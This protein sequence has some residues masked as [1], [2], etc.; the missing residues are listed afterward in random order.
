VAR[1]V[2]GRLWAPVV[3]AAVTTS[4]LGVTI[5]LATAWKSNLVAW[6]IVVALTA[7]SAVLAL[8][9]TRRQADRPA[10]AIPELTVRNASI[11]R[12]NIQLGQVGGDVTIER[13]A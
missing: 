10:P 9:I 3:A 11:G 7:L 4:A 13:D 12:D 5:N 1:E 2:I 6:A 8:W